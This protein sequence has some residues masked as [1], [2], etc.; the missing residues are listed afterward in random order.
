MYY[1]KIKISFVSPETPKAQG[2]K[3]GFNLMV[4]HFFIFVENWMVYFSV[5]LRTGS[6]PADNNRF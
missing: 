4:V 5:W 2:Y 3:T 1:Y 6:N